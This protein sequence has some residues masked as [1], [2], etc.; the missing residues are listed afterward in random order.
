MFI[1]TNKQGGAAV[2]DPFSMGGTVTKQM[3]QTIEINIWVPKDPNVLTS[4]F[5]ILDAIDDH[6]DELRK[7]QYHVSQQ[8]SSIQFKLKEIYPSSRVFIF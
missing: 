7:F 2:S 4:E 3:F 6:P 1:P 8:P 5:K